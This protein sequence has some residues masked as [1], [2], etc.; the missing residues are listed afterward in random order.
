MPGNKAGGLKAS[1]TNKKKYGDDFYRNIGSLGGRATGRKGFA[2]NPE[3]ARKAGAKG[4]KKSRRTGVTT[5][6]G[7][8]K[9]Y[10]YNNG[11]NFA[12]RKESYGNVCAESKPKKSF[13]KKIFGGK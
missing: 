1:A 5:G 10:C 9:E 8:K 3:L 6:Q 13:I 2:V 12:T 11:G 4:G 7:K